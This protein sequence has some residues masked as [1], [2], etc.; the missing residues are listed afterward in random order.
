[1][2]LSL[3]QRKGFDDLSFVRTFENLKALTINHPSPY[4]LDRL[5][6]SLTKLSLLDLRLLNGP[7]PP[8][9]TPIPAPSDTNTDYELSIPTRHIAEIQRA[10][11]VIPVNGILGPAT[12][13]AIGDYLVA[14]GLPRFQVISPRI[15]DNYLGPAIDRVNGDCAK[16]G[17]QNATEVGKS[18][19]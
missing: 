5:P 9:P 14:R 4:K 17:F 10:L 11:C 3:F 1:L 2:E 12:R 18:F 13:R 19:N 15:D 16:A 7:L 8:I 6:K